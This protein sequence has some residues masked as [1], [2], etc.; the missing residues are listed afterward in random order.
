MV[1]ET[2]S[3]IIMNTLMECHLR[4]LLFDIQSLINGIVILFS[5]R[6]GVKF[7]YS[8]FIVLFIDAL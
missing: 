5:V 4:D 2:R 6:K 3:V 8:S 1:E 7:I